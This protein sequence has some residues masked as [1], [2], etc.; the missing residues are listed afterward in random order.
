ML[1]SVLSLSCREL[2]SRCDAFER[3]VG[4]QESCASER[5]DSGSFP[6]RYTNCIAVYKLSDLCGTPAEDSQ[7]TI[8]QE[9]GIMHRWCSLQ[10]KMDIGQQRKAFNSLETQIHKSAYIKDEAQD[11]K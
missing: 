11:Y 4:V 2:V 3:C 10:H 5:Q 8:S 9:D 1:L 7:A 6:A